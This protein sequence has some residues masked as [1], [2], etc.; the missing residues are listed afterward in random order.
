[1]EGPTLPPDLAN[2]I[3][4]HI[5]ALKAINHAGSHM[6]AQYMV[7]A[8]AGFVDEARTYQMSIYD[9]E[10]DLSSR[11]M[12]EDA[13]LVIGAELGARL[14]AVLLSLDARFIANTQPARR[15]FRPEEEVA[16]MSEEAR[17]QFIASARERMA[18]V[19]NADAKIQAEFDAYLED[20]QSAKN[21]APRPWNSRVPLE[22]GNELLEDLKFHGYV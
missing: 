11:N 4:A 19:E 9:Y 1:M 3:N 14:E 8:W 18:K 12:L 15:S 7:D 21:L 22:P 2:A 13:A 5:D 10:N 17:A 6:D 16:K 20:L